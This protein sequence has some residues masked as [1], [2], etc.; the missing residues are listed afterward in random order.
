MCNAEPTVT[1]YKWVA[2]NILEAAMSAP[3]KCTNW[4]V[5]EAWVD[6][7]AVA[8]DSWDEFLTMLVPMDM[9]T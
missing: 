4:N 8:V 3:R 6:E 1:P 2:P 7:R 5:L 9:D